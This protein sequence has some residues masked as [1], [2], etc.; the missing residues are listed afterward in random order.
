[1][2]SHTSCIPTAIAIIAILDISFMERIQPAEKNNHRVR[3]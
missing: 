1:M 2:G 3:L